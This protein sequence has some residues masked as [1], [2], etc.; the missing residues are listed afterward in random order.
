M[1]TP[2]NPMQAP[3][4]DLITQM[5][6]QA[7]GQQANAAGNT[8][9]APQ[10][11]QHQVPQPQPFRP[12]PQQGTQAVGPGQGAA[13]RDQR[14]QNFSTSIQNLVGAVTTTIQKR[15]ARQEQKVFDNF[16]NYA[17]GSQDA[18]GQMQEAMAALKK[19]P[20]DKEAYQRYLQAKQ[21]Y[22]QNMQNLNDLVSGKNEKNAKLLAKGYGIDDKNAGTPERQAAI[23]AIKKTMPGVQGNAANLM[24]RMPQAQQLTPQAQGQAQAVQAG[25]TAKAPTGASILN[26]A[27]KEDAIKAAKEQAIDK[28]KASF[29]EVLPKMESAGYSFDKGSDGNPQFDAQGFPKVHVMTQEERDKNP[30]SAA[31]NDLLQATI[32]LKKAQT[33]A[34]MNPNNP[35][36]KV[37]AA[38]ASARL[39]N[40]S[41]VTNGD[42]KDIAA[43]IERGDLPPTMKSLYRN[44]AS[45]E[46]ELARRGVPLAKMEADWMAT[47]K[48]L[49]TLNGPQQVRLRQAVQFTSDSLEI[50]DDLYSKWLKTGLPSG[51]KEFNR[52]ALTAAKSLPGEAGSIANRLDAQLN[53][54]TSELGTVYKGGNSSTDESLKLAAGNLKAEWNTKTFHDAIQQVRTNLKIRQNSIKNSQ[55]EGGNPDSPYRPTQDTSEDDAILKMLDDR[56]NL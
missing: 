22:D 4:A 36:L 21:A 33:D 46:A 23:A 55:V 32:D 43:G 13:M 35:S 10:V 42:A 2:P 8:Q 51:F 45:V 49:A 1:G 29:I 6:G 50:I 12:Q 19:N 52:A 28:R 20:Q 24:S 18:Q 41:L 31:K 25:L 26:F 44:A 9:V 15:K 16:A 48:L 14:M 53:D 11:P 39:R 56:G 47:N 38:E 7:A 40:A 3:P 17:K 34:L 37:K 5:L 30:A 27:S 54:L